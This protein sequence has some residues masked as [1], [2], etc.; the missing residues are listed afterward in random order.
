M[1]NVMAVIMMPVGDI[2]ELETW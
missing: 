2:W 1:L